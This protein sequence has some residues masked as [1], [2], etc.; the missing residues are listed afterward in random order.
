MSHVNIFLWLLAVTISLP[1]KLHIK[2]AKRKLQKWYSVVRI[3][4]LLQA[5]FWEN[6]GENTK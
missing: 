4:T 3:D 5:E 1:T 2:Q 6:C